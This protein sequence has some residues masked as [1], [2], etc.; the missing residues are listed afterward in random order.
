ME[1][2]R[3]DVMISGFALFA[4]FFGAGNL[5][6]PPYLGVISGD[7]WYLSM[8]GFLLTDPVLPILGVIVTAKLGGGITDIGRRVSENFAKLLGTLAILNI[9]PLFCVPRTASTTYEIFTSQIFP[10][11]PG[12]LSSL[13]FFGITLYVTLHPSK[14]IN[15]IGKYLTPALLIILGIIV[16][17]SIV[18]PPDPMVRTET[19]GLFTLGFKEGYQTM[20][21][22]GSPLMVSIVVGDL[23]R[24]GYT[25]KKVQFEMT[26]R[27]GIVAF[28]LLALVYGSLTYAGA[29][30]GG[31]FNADSERTALLIGMVELMIGG[32]GKIFMGLAIALACLTTSIGLTSTCGNF[33]SSISNGKVSYKTVV[34]ISVAVSYALS[35][36]SVDELISVAVPVLS[37]IYPVVIVIIIMSIFDS[38]IKYNWTYTGAVAGA[39]IISV[40]KSINLASVMRG[41]NLLQGAV[42]QID[43]LP[44][45]GDGFEWLVPAIVMSIIF[46]LI[47]W[48]GKVGK[49]IDDQQ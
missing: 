19:T 35:F 46:T 22:L 42:N 11:I 5:I 37:A 27:V 39:F 47:S 24:K 16:V 12:W 48:I 30:V 18:N 44:L 41:G 14:V 23:I 4:I 20:D 36:L 28:I 9:G 33:F 17:T 6:F 13:I 15:F 26:K 43:K 1:I 21:A 34:L 10:V 40:I 3:K 38:K 49:T 29:T 25:D 8:F 45:A 32:V 2:K 31:H 7:R